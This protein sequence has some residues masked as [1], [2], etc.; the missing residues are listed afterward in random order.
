MADGLANLAV[1]TVLTAPAPAVSGTTLVLTAGQG[2]RMPSTPFQAT[3]WPAGT[4]PDPTTA[5][6]VRVTARTSDTL[7]IIRT[8]EASTARTITAGDQFAATITRRTLEPLGGVTT[9]DD[10]I[11]SGTTYYL[12]HR[13]CGDER[14]EHTAIAY[15]SAAA[16]GASVVE[17]SF[18]NTLDGQLVCMHDL[19]LDRTTNLTGN[20]NARTWPELTN[21]GVVDIGSQLLGPSWANQPIPLLGQVLSELAGKVSL[22]VENKPGSS[23]NATKLMALWAKYGPKDSFV[24]KTFRVAVIGGIPAH[25]QTVRT[26][27]YKIWAYFDGTETNPMID[28]TAAAADLVGVVST[29]SDATISY[30]VS[31]GTPVIVYEVHRRSERDRFAAL[32]VK[33]MM[34]SGI[35]YVSAAAAISTASRFDTG[36][37]TPGDMAGADTQLPT[38]DAANRALSLPPATNS[39]YLLGSMS[40]VAAAAGTYTITWA[41]R[42]VTPPVDTTTHGDFIFGQT[43]DTRYTH[44]ST[45]NVGGYHTVMRANGQLQLFR[46]DPGSS[47]GTQLGMTSTTTAAVAGTWMTFTLT[48]TPTGITLQRTDDASAQITTT[49]TTY[50]GGY[51]HIAAGSSSAAV[52]WRDVVVS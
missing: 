1:G 17:V 8:S 48:V 13:G 35:T 16:Q 50:R 21:N 19:T 41:M 40:P 22:I 38:W 4:L 36:V 46:H 33:G 11:L 42:W 2:A 49:S 47:T 43:D 26:A 12:A 15:R 14:P 44:Q 3:V 20:V 52:A 31:R 39:S 29:M 7:T 6:V 23:T 27:G 51:L 24:Y 10:L 32:G 30:V 45:S 28:A 37:Q 25:A 5:E 9:L 18:S 34:C